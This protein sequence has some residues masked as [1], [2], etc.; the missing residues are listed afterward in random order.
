MLSL[1]MEIP[2]IQD[3]RP[4][5]VY[6]NIAEKGKYIYYRVLDSY[7]DLDYVQA[8]TGAPLLPPKGA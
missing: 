3:I 2:E 4:D 8:R 7:F 1:E 5:E 6:A